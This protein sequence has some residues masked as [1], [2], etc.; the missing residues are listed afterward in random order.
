MPVAVF[1]VTRLSSEAIAAVNRTVVAG[2]K[3][4]LAG[5]SA[6]C[7][8]RVEHLASASA[9]TAFA[10]VAANLAALR[11]VG[12]AFFG[13]ELLFTGRKREF[14]SAILADE[15]LVVVHEIPLD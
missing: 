11:L 8:Y 10:R 6:L 12:E 4:N 14:L 1:S 13:V 3:R 5:L 2:L 9:R 15:G 7:A